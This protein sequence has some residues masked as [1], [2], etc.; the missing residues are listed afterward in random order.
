MVYQLGFR[1]DLKDLSLPL[2][3]L[4]FLAKLQGKR[5]ELRG[6]R[7]FDAAGCLSLSL[8]LLTLKLN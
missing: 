8:V 6:E 4:A 2:G 3:A 5:A 1:T 7:V